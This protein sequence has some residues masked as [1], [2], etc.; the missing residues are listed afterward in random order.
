[1][2]IKKK[3]EKEEILDLKIER[4]RWERNFENL[5]NNSQAR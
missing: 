2:P 5:K 4:R 1:M 3:D